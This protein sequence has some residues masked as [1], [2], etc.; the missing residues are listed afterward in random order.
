MPRGTQG[1]ILYGTFIEV[2]VDLFSLSVWVGW[3]KRSQRGRPY[4]HIEK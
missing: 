2:A 4:F 3:A 1:K